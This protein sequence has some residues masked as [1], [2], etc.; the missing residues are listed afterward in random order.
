MSSVQFDLGLIKIFKKNLKLVAKVQAEGYLWDTP[1]G[2]VGKGVEVA[3]VK[4]N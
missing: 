1:S 2:Y 3:A 4:G